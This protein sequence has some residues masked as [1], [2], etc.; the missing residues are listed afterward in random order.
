MED[1]MSKAPR[2]RSPEPLTLFLVTM[3]FLITSCA[4]AKPKP[5]EEPRGTETTFDEGE[6]I[7]P[8]EFEDEGGD[9]WINEDGEIE[10]E[11]SLNIVALGDSSF[12]DG[13]EITASG[14]VQIVG[15]PEELL[16]TQEEIDALFEDIAK[17]TGPS[18]RV[19]PITPSTDDDVSGGVSI[20]IPAESDAHSVVG[21]GDTIASIQELALNDRFGYLSTAGGA[22]LA[23]LEYKTLPAIEALKESPR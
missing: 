10:G 15:S 3:V 7:G 9:E 13:S 2:K 21:G 14:N 20:V 1:E 17:D 8:N 23:Y 12:S 19:G 4:G 22:M 11:G 18:P 6:I 5:T 16:A